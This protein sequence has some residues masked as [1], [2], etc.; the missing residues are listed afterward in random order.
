MFKWVCSKAT[1][2]KR[3]YCRAGQ[4]FLQQAETVRLGHPGGAFV[5]VTDLDAA[6]QL[7]N[8]NKHYYCNVTADPLAFLSRGEL[9]LADVFV[10]GVA[11]W[12]SVVGEGE[13]ELG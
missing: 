1:K 9:V 6:L 7:R 11:R 10:L 4:I 5:L 3:H 13:R 8:D 12:W 2:K